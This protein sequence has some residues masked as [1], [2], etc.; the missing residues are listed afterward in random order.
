MSCNHLDECPR[1]RAEIEALEDEIE[2]LEAEIE[3]LKGRKEMSE[4]L[5]AYFGWPNRR[6]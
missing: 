6:A 1:C 3:S 5:V 2:A 4:A